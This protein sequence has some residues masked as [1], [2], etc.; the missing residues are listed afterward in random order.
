VSQRNK[1][2]E[3]LSKEKKNLYN[4]NNNLENKIIQYLN[5]TG[6]ENVIDDINLKI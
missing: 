3:K 5:S 6:Q 1:D 4:E 2:V